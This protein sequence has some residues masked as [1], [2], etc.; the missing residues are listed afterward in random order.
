MAHGIGLGI[1]P[2]LVEEACALAS[3]ATP[4]T[5]VDLCP[6]SLRPADIPP[7]AGA[8]PL[9][10]ANLERL[11][12][13]VLPE[14]VALALTDADD[15]PVVHVTFGTV[16]A[17]PADLR[18]TAQAI[19]ALGVLVIV[20]GRLDAPSPASSWPTTRRTRCSCHAAGPWS[21]RPAPE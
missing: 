19:A 11:P 20:S 4:A 16:Y 8:L 7:P 17:N 12:G 3:H 6:P 9:R 18:R 14:A 13:E 10:A 5:W 1:R 2:A 21:P 15:R